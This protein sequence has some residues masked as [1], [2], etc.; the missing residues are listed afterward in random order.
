M[1]KKSREQK[2]ADKSRARAKKRHQRQAQRPA[3][4]LGSWLGG[5]PFD[6]VPD[7]P[8]GFRPL[9]MTQAML[10]FAAP[11]MDYVEQGTIQD[12]NA[13]L[14]L[15]MQLWNYTLPTISM[16]QRPSRPAIVHAIQTTLHMDQQAAEAFC[17][18]MITRKAS[19]FPDEIQ[20]EG[21]MTMFMRKEVDYLI[22]PFAE[23]QLQVSNTPIPPE[24]DD[25]PFLDALR[26]LE[27]RIAAH[28]DYGA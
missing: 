8:P 20:P 27:A 19:L 28:V 22:T 24:S 26:Q 12:P 14:Q 9:P 16:A 18:R 5:F 7:A 1:P 2:R 3:P 21:S 11:L 25:R 13:A 17:E 6:D 23:S 4:P 15:G 10:E